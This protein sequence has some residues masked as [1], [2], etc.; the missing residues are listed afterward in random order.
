MVTEE[1]WVALSLAGKKAH[2]SRSSLIRDCIDQVTAEVLRQPTSTNNEG[3]SDQLGPSG[4]Q[5]DVGDRAS[6]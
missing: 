2:R 1:H 6:T 3:P 5:V 4:N